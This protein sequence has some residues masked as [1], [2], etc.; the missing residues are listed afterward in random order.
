MT[1]PEDISGL[2]PDPQQ[3]SLLS[4]LLSK[5]AQVQGGSS[6]QMLLAATVSQI[7]SQAASLHNGAAHFLH[8]SG[9]P[10]VDQGNDARFKQILAT[11]LKHE[12][13]AYVQRDGSESSKFGI[14]QSTAREFGY[15][16][17]IRNMSRAQ[18][19]A[20]Y[21]KIWDRSG[22]ASLPYPLSLVHFDTYVNSPTAAMKLLGK[23]GGSAE[24]YLAMRARRYTRLAELRPARY[25]RYLKGWMNRVADLRNITAEHTVLS[26]FA[27][28]NA[29]T[30]GGTERTIIKA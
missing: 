16:G 15:K 12:G 6:F 17:S 7:G 21:K 5:S 29:G 4:K 3:A 9:S 10:M 24:A 18:A 2:V 14:L 1:L 30:A 13:S 22:A 26:R 11:V 25:G 23:S 20:V 19:E 28:K 27:G 8:A